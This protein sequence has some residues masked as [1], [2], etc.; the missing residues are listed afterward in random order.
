MALRLSTTHKS[1][2][3]SFILII[4]LVQLSVTIHAQTDK[5]DSTRQRRIDIFPAISYSPE[6]KLTLGALG[7]WYP[8][9]ANNETGNV[10]SFIN[11]RIYFI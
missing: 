5:N 11:F 1:N 3:L 10:Q 4:M 8:N 9:F 6:T 2:W 7:Y